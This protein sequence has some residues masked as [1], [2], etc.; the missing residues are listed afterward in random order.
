[1][2]SPAVSN[3]GS[4]ALR[5]QPHQ[6]GLLML[7]WSRWM[8][9]QTQ[10]GR[11]WPGQPPP[12]TPCRITL[13]QMAIHL[14]VMYSQ[15]TWQACTC[16]RLRAQS[17]RHQTLQQAAPCKH[18]SVVLETQKPTGS[19]PQSV[20]EG[21]SVTAKGR[22]FAQPVVTQFCAMYFVDIPGF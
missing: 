6:A 2:S 22:M 18:L 7:T 1:M 14:A 9:G 15:Q 8:K 5:L 4:A 3:R 21:I 19:K 16:L 17:M 13:A 12:P 11:S 10:L 20:V